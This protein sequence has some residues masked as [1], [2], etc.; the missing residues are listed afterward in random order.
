MFTAR[1]KNSIWIL[2]TYNIMLFGI[3]IVYLALI[4]ILL[5]LSAIITA[6]IYNNLMFRMMIT[7]I[8]VEETFGAQ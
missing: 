5:P 4:S 6:I 7:F 2:P 8:F 1:K 3:I